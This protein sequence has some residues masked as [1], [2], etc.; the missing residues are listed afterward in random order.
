V[1][2]KSGLGSTAFFTLLQD[3]RST[4][5]GHRTERQILLADRDLFILEAG[6]AV[7]LEHIVHRYEE[8]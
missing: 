5:L 7:Y 2:A 6:K 3:P 8:E 1:P 4:T